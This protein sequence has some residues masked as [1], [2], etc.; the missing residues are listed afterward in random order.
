MYSI[1]VTMIDYKM[2]VPNNSLDYKCIVV[3]VVYAWVY[4]ILIYLIRIKSVSHFEI[5]RK[6]FK[7]QWNLFLL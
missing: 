7:I 6:V 1:N 5:I 3:V 4:K 2:I